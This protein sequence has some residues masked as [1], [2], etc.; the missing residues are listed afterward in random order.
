MELKII[1]RDDIRQGYHIPPNNQTFRSGICSVL[2][3]G[4]YISDV[5][6]HPVTN[7]VFVL[8][9]PPLMDRIKCQCVSREQA[10]KYKCAQKERDAHLPLVD[11]P[12]K[13]RIQLVHD[14]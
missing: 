7:E 4:C 12:F 9:T 2:Q 13:P 8:L 14:D 3:F 11:S 1:L 6:R 10:E 5:L